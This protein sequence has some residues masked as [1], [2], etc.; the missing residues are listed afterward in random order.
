MSRSTLAFAVLAIVVGPSIASAQGLG[1]V[2]RAIRN[3]KPNVNPGGNP[4]AAPA[5]KAE[6]ANPGTDANALG[7]TLEKVTSNVAEQLDLPKDQGLV[8]KKVLDDSPAAK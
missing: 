6:Q 3:L 5:P 4:K 2:A 7:L 8:L 1:G